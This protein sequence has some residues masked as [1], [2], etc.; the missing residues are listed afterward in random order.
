MRQFGVTVICCLCI[1]LIDG[2]GYIRMTTDQFLINLSGIDIRS[3]IQL[4]KSEPQK[5][6]VLTGRI[7]GNLPENVQIAVLA[8]SLQSS[9]STNKQTIQLASYTIIQKPGSYTL[10]VAPGKYH[11]YA[12]V[13][14]NKNNSLEDDEYVGRYGRPSTVYVTDSQ[15]V[16]GLDIDAS[17]ILHPF[18]E[19][20]ISVKFMRH[21]IE[22]DDTLERG[23]VVT[24]NETK[25]AKDFGEM[26]LWSSAEF[27]QKNGVNIYR[28][29]FNYPVLYDT[30]E[31]ELRK[32][33]R[34]NLNDRYHVDAMAWMC[35]LLGASRQAHY[36]S[37]L[38]M[39]A[40]ETGNVKLKRYAE[41]NV[42]RLK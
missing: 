1:S 18:A 2:C 31:Q 19:M 3:P 25:F 5:N 24:L 38:E 7:T 37:T 35:Q 22:P 17:G 28:E 40:L 15:V 33:Y 20:P 30:A 6:C 42:H 32:G 34:T 36:R 23:G 27:I 10:F 13:D 4:Y 9:R 29:N 21:C 39:V 14:R 16:D 12:F 8:Y 41:R 11:L 26:G